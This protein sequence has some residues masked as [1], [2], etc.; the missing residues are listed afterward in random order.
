M[1]D[2]K[3][4]FKGTK[5]E[6]KITKY[7]KKGFLKIS[8]VKRKGFKVVLESKIKD[9]VDGLDRKE[10]V[11]KKVN[12]DENTND[13][14]IEGWRDLKFMQQKALAKKKGM[15]ISNKT[16]GDDVTYF[17]ESCEDKE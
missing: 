14:S 13:V 9:Y 15:K 2:K 12:P 3:I 1:S 7:V 11:A 6:V 17:L 5:T 4:Y 8:E 16:G 10:T